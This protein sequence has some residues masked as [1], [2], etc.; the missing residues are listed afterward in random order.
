MKNL[1]LATIYFF[2]SRFFFSPQLEIFRD[3]SSLY[4]FFSLDLL[5]IFFLNTSG[6]SRKVSFKIRLNHLR[7]LSGNKSYGP[8]L[9]ALQWFELCK[10]NCKHILW[11]TLVV[12]SV[13]FMT[14]TI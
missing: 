11:L 5:E 2:T 1:Q 14:D 7:E 4:A 9:E 13:E 12:F 10:L 6:N 3:Q 8:D